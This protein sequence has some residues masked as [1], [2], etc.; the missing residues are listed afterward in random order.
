M[1]LSPQWLDQLRG[2]ITLSSL[3]GRSVKVQKA[4]REYKACCP[5]H[6]EKTPSFTINDQK[7]FYHCFGCGAHGDAIRWMTDHRGLGFM[8]AVK[9]L[10]SEA[11]MDVPAPDPQAAQ[12]AEKRTTLF[13]VCASAQDWFVEQLDTVEGAA[14]RVY[15]E[16]RGI[17]AETQ[18]AFGFG[19][20]PDGRGNIAKALDGFPQQQL[21]EAGLLIQVEG[22]TPYDRFRGRLMLPIKDARGRVIAFG[23]RILGDG[24][25]KYLNSPDTP[26]FDKGRT[27]YNMDKAAAASRKTG[28]LLVV[29]GYMDAIALAQAGFEDVVAPLGTALTEEQIAMAWKMAERPIL[30]LD[31]DNAGQ[32]AAMRAASRA[33]PM[34][35]AGHSFAFAIMPAGM[36][37]DDVLQKSGR[38]AMEG[39]INDARP[40][41]DHIWHYEL[42]QAALA[43]PEEKAAFKAQLLSYAQTIGDGDVSSLYRSAFMD[44]FYAMLRNQKPAFGQIQKR[45]PWQKS[46]ISTAPHAI[47]RRIAASSGTS[48]LIRAIL[49]GLLQLPDQIL[50]NQEAL[51]A[52]N[53]E[54]EHL[55]HFLQAMITAAIQQPDLDTQQLHTILEQQGLGDVKAS[56]MHALNSLPF[57]FAS[58][59]LTN[60]AATE[61]SG[62]TGASARKD[63]QEVLQIAIAQPRL[64]IRLKKLA[65]ELDNDPSDATFA[66]Y[67]ELQEQR[68]SFK[69]R[70][71]DLAERARAR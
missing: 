21:V 35:R 66:H 50:E 23:G 14:A 32:K 33:L 30:C 68:R 38:R 31:G 5:F 12:R 54:D 63:L 6:S 36:D 7:G 11:G 45:K 27:L 64:E 24:E 26:L 48:A 51:C 34:L 41:L 67:A 47:T 46:A 60:P 42:S 2:R 28:R 59:P 22:K 18:R 70:I 1:S 44:K 39:L 62:D 19:F 71:S 57:S 15:L 43:T 13:D 9:E 40:M 10:A 25:P 37:P 52:L 55:Q 3:I 65:E 29:E 4:G 17:S 8:D 61:A 53:C 58:P 49:S 56:L 16:K 20:A 69:Q